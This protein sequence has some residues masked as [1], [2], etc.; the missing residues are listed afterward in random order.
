MGNE[1]D[2]FQFLLFVV[3]CFGSLF[4]LSFSFLVLKI[5]SFK[6]KKE[7]E[8]IPARIEDFAPACRA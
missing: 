5:A 6:G 4:L 3:A 2:S 7:V 8:Q 1:H